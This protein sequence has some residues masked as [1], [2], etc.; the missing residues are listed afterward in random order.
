LRVSWGRRIGIVGGLLLAAVS[1]VFAAEQ[2]DGRKSTPVAT[3]AAPNNVAVM[4]APV[5][6]PPDSPTGASSI[7]VRGHVGAVVD[8]SASFRVRVY[9]NNRFKRDTKL[10]PGDDQFTVGDV[11]LIEG[12]NTIT[13]TVSSGEYET[14]ASAPVTVER[15]ATPPALKITSPRTD[16]VYGDT[17]LLSGTTDAGAQLELVNRTNSA[18]AEATATSGG[19]FSLS[20]RLAMGN[21]VLALGSVDAA[22]NAT[23]RNLTIQRALSKA[24]VTVEL[25]R[26][27]YDLANLPA[28][29]SMAAHV[30]GPDG[31]PADGATVTFSISPPGQT[32]VTR[33]AETVNG[34]ATWANY[35]LLLSGAQAGSG[36][37]TVLAKLD[38][39]ESL[40]GS[41]V[42]SFH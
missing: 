6:D 23:H 41:A 30:L 27:T 32:T 18:R 9:V 20:L 35:P 25:S 3:T 15:D 22:G 31:Q 24:A 17:L 34:V 19:E 29:I 4:P 36:L 21:N 8:A 38:D 16:T 28:T 12:T 26:E 11:P 14:A 13:A 7:R 5:L 2:F 10:Q 1:V 42:F 37:V 39:G 33:Q 40:A